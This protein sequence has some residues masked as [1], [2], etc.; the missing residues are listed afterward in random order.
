MLHEN[1]GTTGDE[2]EA[3]AK[4]LC[5]AV[6]I[7]RKGML[8][9]EYLFDGSL[10]DSNVQ[11]E[12]I[13]SQLLFFVRKL[14]GGAGSND[15]HQSILTLSQLLYYNTV[16]RRRTVNTDNP[17][18]HRSRETPV[19]VYV[20]LMVHNATGSEAL[21]DA[22]FRLGLSISYDRVQEIRKILGDQICQEFLDCG[23]VWA[24]SLPKGTPKAYGFDNANKTSASTTAS[25][26][27]NFNG[28][29]IS[30]FSFG[31]TNET[32]KS[33]N[34]YDG[35]PKNKLQLPEYYTNID[36]VHNE[37]PV[38]PSVEEANLVG[39]ASQVEDNCKNGELSW[40]KKVREV[41]SNG[42]EIDKAS[43]VSWAA[44]FASKEEQTKKEVVSSQILPVFIEEAATPAMVK[45][46]L[47]VILKA[48]E[49][50]NP[51]EIPWVTADQP[52]YA[53]LKII[54]WRYPDTLG[55]N[56]LFAVLGALH[57]EKAAWTCVGQ[58]EDGSGTPGIM[59]DANVTTIGVAES[60]LHCAHISRSRYLNTVSACVL[61]MLL[62]DAYQEYVA[63]VPAGS[64]PIDMDAWCEQQPSPMFR[65]YYFLLKLKLLV[66]QFVRS[67]RSGDKNTYLTT[68]TS[69]TYYFFALN[70]IHYA[71]WT[72]V[73]IRDMIL[74]PTMHPDVDEHFKK[75]RFTINKTG[76][77]FSNIGLD[78]GQEQNIKK[79]KQHGGPLSFTHSPDQLLLYLISGPEVTNQ[80][81]FFQNLIS[82]AGCDTVCHHEQ[83]HAY[84]NM[85]I[86]HTKSLY[87][88][89]TEIGNVFTD[90]T[91]LLYNLATDE[92]RP[93]TT[94]E[95][96]VSLQ[97]LGK[98]QYEDYVEQR[99]VQR[100]I[101]IHV[102]IAMNKNELMKTT[103][104]KASSKNQ[105]V[106]DL[107]NLAATLSQLY[108]ANEVR[109]GDTSE[110]FK[111]ENVENPPSIS[112]DGHLYH[113]TK[114]DLVEELIATTPLSMSVAQQN[115]DAV[116]L[117]GPAI[118]HMISPKNG[119]TVEEYCEVFISH[120]QKFFNVSNR[121]DV[122]FDIYMQSS[123][124]EGVR[125]TR[126]V[127]PPMIV[128]GN[129]KVKNWSRFLKNDSNKQSLF[130]YIATI[131][132][133]VKLS[134]N[135]Q[136]VFTCSDTVV[137]NPNSEM[138]KE[139]LSPCD[140]E[141]ADTRMILHLHQILGETASSVTLRTVDT[142][143]IVLAIAASAQ[144][145]DKNIYI[146]FGVGDN[147]KILN[148][149]A[150]RSEIGMD[151]A[152]ALP[153][154]HAF[155]GCDTVSSFKSIG[156]KTAWERWKTFADVTEA[157]NN[158]NKGPEDIDS[159]TQQLL[160]R[161]VV[162]LYDRTSGC[163]TTNEL[164]KELF[165]RGRS[166]DKIPPTSGVVLQH[167]RRTAYQG[168]HSWGNTSIK[169]QNLPEAKLWGWM[170][171]K[172]GRYQPFWTLDPIASKGCKQ[173]V[174]CGCDEKDGVFKCAK[175]CGCKKV[176]EVCT[177]LCKCKGICQH[178]KTL[179]LKTL[180]NADIGDEEVD[181]A[182]DDEDE[183]ED[184]D[185]DLALE[186]T[187]D[188]N[189]NDDVEFDFDY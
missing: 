43:N 78:H 69:L 155:T 166:I 112:K 74:L 2:A 50:T 79:F 124:K 148:A 65:Y 176:G 168:G 171:D 98:Q 29:V 95:S 97:S 131:S 132:Q 137:T 109:G 19:A 134:D 114:S 26:S 27:A 128:R 54:Q 56:K 70:H 42:S 156:K 10:I 24:Y 139:Y 149:H 72:P 38:V 94:I 177:A 11:M 77:R 186:E 32:V 28:T 96:I 35:N 25:G 189:V 184:I 172:E 57:I 93:S 138:I 160:G 68:L 61:R 154:F 188:D 48:H 145:E 105:E 113:G 36:P 133:T 81:T 59:A 34:I 75:G 150:I 116:I 152:L 22:L 174:K 13:S 88:K 15:V 86:Q 146:Q 106:K 158:L 187:Y 165:T 84:Q 147:K 91:N 101:A 111:H 66:L 104:K 12:C 82:P 40:M 89:Y 135:Q 162:L 7:L 73:H 9:N 80:V 17:R 120:I 141:E 37:R 39:D 4:I 30:V 99:L 92:A 51:G 179:I 126:G 181:D 119:S 6:R 83:T 178:S 103:K 49:H 118:V 87:A 143:V 46:C 52:L 167:D 121:I 41:I 125:K 62:C 108:V 136:L 21:V 110:F 47:T 127:A 55:E 102:T 20:G 157:F 130:Q 140:H 33:F 122:V 71:R 129:T 3:E 164:R 182:D 153:V 90:D 45:H 5:D 60:C 169:Q 123:L 8:L 53:L 63:Q 23:V 67:V 163:A 107:K 183:I 185:E 44:F 16:K 144:Y 14:L 159:H 151:K 173:L 170:K 76:K 161:F 1:V 100:T 85:F 18:H 64:Q 180:N 175:R 115:T 58:V 117:D 31:E 142:D